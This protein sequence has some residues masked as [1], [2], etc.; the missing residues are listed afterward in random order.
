M[1]SLGIRIPANTFS[2]SLGNITPEKK[3]HQP[4][5][6]TGQRGVTKGRRK[7]QLNKLIESE[8]LEGK[9]KFQRRKKG[10]GEE[11]QV[12]EIQ[13]RPKVVPHSCWRYP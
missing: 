5:N 6:Q 3:C 8:R 7:I 9:E 2:I 10:T 13:V 4:R 11:E 12:S 1:K